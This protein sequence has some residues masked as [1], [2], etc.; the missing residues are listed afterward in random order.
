MSHLLVVSIAQTPAKIA[1]KALVEIPVTTH[2]EIQQAEM[3]GAP[4]APE[5]APLRVRGTVHLHVKQ[6]VQQHARLGVVGIVVD[7][8]NPV[9][10][11]H[12]RVDAL[13]DVQEDVTIGVLSPALMVVKIRV[14]ALV[15]KDV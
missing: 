15:Q 12:V 14:Q 8:V 9:A 5:D 3:A 6:V 4:I 10:Q 7:L 11:G 1:V 2:V 13:E